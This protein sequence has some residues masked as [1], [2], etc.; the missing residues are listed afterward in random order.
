[1]RKFMDEDFLLMT[2]TA[3][4]LYRNT[5]A[6]M[7]IIDYHCHINPREIAE[8]KTYENI[9]QV[10]LYGD[11]YKWR[12]MRSS[13]V[14]EKYITG[15][16]TDYEKFEKYA[17]IMPMLIGNPLY[18][19]SHLELKRYFNIDLPLSL[20]NAPAIWEESNR[21][22]KEL[23]VK[24][25]I[26][27][28]GVEVICTTDDPIDNLEWHKKIG[29]DK[30]FGT[31]VLPACRPDR[32]LN[33]EKA[34]FSGYIKALGDTAGVEIK[35]VST[36]KEALSKRF[37]FFN[38]LGCKAAD[39]GLDF[40]PFVSAS[41]HETDIIF[42]KAL[43]GQTLS[44]NEI[45]IYK[46]NILLFCASQ[47]SRLGW[48]MELHYGVIRNANTSMF[49]KLGADTGFDS[50][51]NPG[52]PAKLLSL[53]DSLDQN[54][55]LPKTLIFP[56]TP[57]DN[58]AIGT[59]IGCFQDSSVRGKLQ[60]GSAWWFNDTKNGMEEQLTTYASLSALGNFVGFLTDSRSFL[61]Y[62]RHE[63]FRRILCNL[64]GKTVENGEYPNDRNYI[65]KLISD[66]SY[67]NA[68]KYFGF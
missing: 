7:P 34:D 6:K 11:H 5:A 19:W 12:A 28:S 25:I 66:I 56:I 63:Y 57:S 14:D 39:H 16:S 50:I 38:T 44:L 9:T 54:K 62:T 17:E 26:K 37:D 41:E 43:D 61:S 55:T 33:L 1:M 10:W 67:T 40:I 23:S 36:L 64:I 32:A 42:Q 48:V 59:A 35:S 20:E 49:N 27:M 58:A 60:Q 3:C 2:E 22:I 31:K 53:L 15:E 24:N 45:E 18:H 21:K 46:T 51:G 47:Y 13:G 4:E 30:S 65:E 29:Q 8:N 68:K 52:N